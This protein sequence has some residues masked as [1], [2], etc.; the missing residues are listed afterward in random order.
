MLKGREREAAAFLILGGGGALVDFAFGGGVGLSPYLMYMLGMWSVAFT[1]L[2]Y[3][4][5]MLHMPLAPLIG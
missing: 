5:G 3:M 1:F 2:M 4:L